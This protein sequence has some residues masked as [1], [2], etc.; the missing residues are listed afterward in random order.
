MPLVVFSRGVALV[1]WRR[2]A[3]K[4]AEAD[5]DG[6]SH[7]MQTIDRFEDIAN[8]VGCDL[9]AQRGG[10]VWNE[11]KIAI[12]AEGICLNA[13]DGFFLETGRQGILSNKQF[14][15]AFNVLDA[16]PCVIS[17]SEAYGGF[18]KVAVED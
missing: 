6:Y 10:Q 1:N 3:R 11:I 12:V 2:R 14:I 13:P 15:R 4:W 5:E 7:R 18:E 8:A 16:R 9:R 17:R